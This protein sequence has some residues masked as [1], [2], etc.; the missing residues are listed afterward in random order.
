MSGRFKGTVN[1]NEPGDKETAYFVPSW[2]DDG[3]YAQSV[4]IA[5]LKKQET[6]IIF[7]KCYTDAPQAHV[8]FIF[9]KKETDM[10]I[11][12]LL[13]VKKRWKTGKV[14]G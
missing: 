3:V 4:A 7:F 9:N 10:L 1:R 12:A 2:H 6:S 11:D 13:E 8:H 14:I 5:P